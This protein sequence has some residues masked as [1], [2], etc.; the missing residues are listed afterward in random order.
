MSALAIYEIAPSLSENDALLIFLR[1]FHTFSAP[2]LY[3]YTVPIS[4]SESDV[5][6]STKFYIFTL[7]M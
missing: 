4:L 2:I 7:A 1:R 5:G 6:K 3:Q